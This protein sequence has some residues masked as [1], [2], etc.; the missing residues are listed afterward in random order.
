MSTRSTVNNIS[1]GWIKRSL[2]TANLG[3]T[4]ATE[5]AKNRV[6][7]IFSDPDTRETLDEQ[8]KTKI[9]A[10]IADKAGRLK[11]LAMKAGQMLSYI[12]NTLPPAARQI[13]ATLQ[14]SSPPMDAATV[15]AIIRAELG[16]DPDELFVQW[17]DQ[18]IAAAS[19][20]QVHKAVTHDGIVMA[21]KVQ[22][23]EIREA[24]DSDFKSLSALGKLLD[25]LLPGGGSHVI[26]EL[27]ERLGDECD[28]RIEL[29]NIEH[30]RKLFGSKDGVKIPHAYPEYSTERVLAT[31]FIAAKKFADF[32]E[33]ATQAQKDRAGR[34]IYELTIQSVWLHHCFN[35]DPHPGNFLFT[36]DKVVFLDFGCVKYFPE[37][38]LI[39]QKRFIKSVL[40][41]DLARFAEECVEEKLVIRPDGFDFESFHRGTLVV[42]HPYAFAEDFTFTPAYVQK[43][44]EMVFNKVD[45][46]RLGM[47]KD[48]TMSNRLWFGLYSILATLNA[49]INAHEIVR[50]LLYTESETFPKVPR[51]MMATYVNRN[52]KA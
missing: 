22:Y 1:S 28:Y 9:A 42:T 17:D 48:L 23:P 46:M 47:P 14:D 34:I 38:F 50:P 4:V 6:R 16:K 8:A 51:G 31:E 13:L 10:L 25:L 19:I 12:D 18:P 40:S 27:R 11:G 2:K 35:A 52:A 44:T 30:F 39:G 33:T 29:R 43:M 49:R 7:R 21:V 15:R 36:E 3:R 24:F 37:K 32:A 41:C 26:D 5:L 20:G 45:T